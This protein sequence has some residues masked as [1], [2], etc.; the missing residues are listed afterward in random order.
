MAK[1]LVAYVDK[2][3]YSQEL[4]EA[5][6]AYQKKS[7]DNSFTHYLVGFGV[8][9]SF[10]ITPVNLPI[11][12]SGDLPGCLVAALQWRHSFYCKQPRSP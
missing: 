6:S 5:V 4:T 7:Q 9:S 1:W 8:V 2:L 11:Q 10:R 3:R 12:S